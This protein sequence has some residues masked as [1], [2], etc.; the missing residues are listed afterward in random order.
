MKTPNTDALLPCPFCGEAP[1]IE[2]ANNP[3]YKQPE[4]WSVSFD[5]KDG[6]VITCV[7]NM[8]P[9]RPRTA[10][11]HPS[12]QHMFHW[13]WNTRTPQPSD[14]GMLVLIKRLAG[15]L[16][17]IKHRDSQWHDEKTISLLREADAFIASPSS[18]QPSVTS[19][20]IASL[21]VDAM[22]PYKL[23][24]SQVNHTAGTIIAQAIL[25]AF[26]VSRKEG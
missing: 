18:P 3:E 6:Q 24:G 16:R 12:N 23:H 8:C 21:V 17:F 4:G 19:E 25:T 5:C 26:H 13:N 2:S 10:V 7:N 20:D 1:Q 15:R 9:M 11:H 14:D 22:K